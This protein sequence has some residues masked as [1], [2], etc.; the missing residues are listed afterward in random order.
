MIMKQGRKYCLIKPTL[1]RTDGHPKVGKSDLKALRCEKVK[2][3]SLLPMQEITREGI[4]VL[5]AAYRAA[6][7][8]SASSSHDTAATAD[9]H[10]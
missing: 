6:V 4:E 8:A 2:A 7:V 5:C 10:I 9:F 3:L 1:L